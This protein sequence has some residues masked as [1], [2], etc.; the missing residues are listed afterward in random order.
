MPLSSAPT[1]R[2]LPQLVHGAKISPV[3]SALTQLL[4]KGDDWTT[5]NPRHVFRGLLRQC[6]YLPDSSARLYFRNYVVKRFRKYNPRPPVPPDLK[7]RLQQVKVQKDLL[8]KAR[9]GLVL[10]QRANEGYSL[11]L[12]R[13]LAMTYGRQGKRRRELLGRLMGDSPLRQELLT[14]LVP[15]PPKVAI[16]NFGSKLE[17]LL[18][19]QKRAEVF[20]RSSGSGKLRDSQKLGSVRLRIPEKNSLG[21]PMPPNRIQNLKEKWYAEL[22]DTIMPPLPMEEWERLKDLANGVIQEEVPRRKR[23][24]MGENDF[25]DAKPSLPLRTRVVSSNQG[26]ALT[27]KRRKGPRANPHRITQRYMRRM[28]TSIFKRCS[29][30]TW[31]VEEKKWNVQWGGPQTKNHSLNT[32]GLQLDMS[33]FE[34]VDEDGKVFSTE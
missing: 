10:L 32:V 2:D 18:N 16:P 4:A 19:A 15:F 12:R 27:I 33:L 7:L 9:K 8:K 23:G 30:M 17:A 24:G 29:C 1:I 28:W 6:T 21:C 31:D 26:Q 13:V 25:S 5:L 20:S 11:H 14:T 34:G 3:S 22:L